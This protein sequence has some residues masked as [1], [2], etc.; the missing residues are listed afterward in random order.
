MRAPAGLAVIREGLARVVADR[1]GTAHGTVHLDRVGI[2]GKWNLKEIENIELMRKGNILVM[3]KIA[4]KPVGADALRFFLS[5]RG[6]GLHFV[7]R[8][9]ELRGK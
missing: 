7:E 4:I 6:M 8:Y 9:Q 5:N 1:Q 3:G 2:A